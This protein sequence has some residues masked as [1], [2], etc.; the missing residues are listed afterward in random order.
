MSI[1]FDKLKHHVEQLDKTLQSH[2]FLDV[3]ETPYPWTNHIYVSSDVRRAHL[4]VVDAIDSKKLY[5]VHLCVF[6][7]QYDTAPIYGFDLIAGPNKVTGA[8]HDFSPTTN[9]NHP[10]CKWFEERVK[11]YEWS[12]PRQ[13]PEWA[14]EIFSP[15]MVAA[16]NVNSEFELDE[17]LKL[18]RESLKYYLNKVHDL[19][20]M[21][22]YEY[23]IE[24]FDSK[25]EQNKYCRNQKLNPHTPKVMESLG[26][27]KE[28]V[29]EFINTCLF[30]EI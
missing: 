25:E 1:I 9:P 10:L 13:L 16:G 6:P 30:P 22:T 27:E 29:S 14:S 3:K 23:K 18:S 28:L 15:S 19:N 4:D 20:Q 7:K 8:F 26:F 2:A 12:K 24:N 17:I 5:M 21:T 11:D